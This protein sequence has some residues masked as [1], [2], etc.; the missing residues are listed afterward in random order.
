MELTFMVVFRMS[1]WD[2]IIITFL[3]SGG[4]GSG[5]FKQYLKIQKELCFYRSSN[6]LFDYISIIA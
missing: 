2:L 6:N 1:T 4:G 5:T 3:I